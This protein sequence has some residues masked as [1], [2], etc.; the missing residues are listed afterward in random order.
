MSLI[1]PETTST[2]CWRRSR[3]PTCQHVLSAVHSVVLDVVA[4]APG[5]QNQASQ[6]AN[7]MANNV[8]Q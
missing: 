7:Q 6:I 8:K 5:V 1:A 2:A 3:N 4:C